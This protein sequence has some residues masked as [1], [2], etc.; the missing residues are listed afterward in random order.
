[1][2]D[3]IDLDR[4]LDELFATPP[5]G[6]TAARNALAKA[7]KAEKRK[8]EADE[9][10]ALRKPGRLV[11]ALNQLGLDED[12][13]LEALLEAADDVRNGGGD[14]FREAVAELRDAVGTAASAAAKRLDPPR[15]TDRA[16]L[17]QALLAI[18]ADDD[19]VSD[20]ADGRLVD[21]PAPDAFG[22]GLPAPATPKAKP[23]PK[24][25]A[26]P[27]AAG[28]ADRPPD[29][30]AIKRAAKR[31]KEAAKEADAADRALAR[32]E[33]AV[34]AEADALAQADTD[35]A[36]AKRAVEDA[37]AALADAKAQLEAA[38][39][40]AAEAVDTQERAAAALAEAQARADDAAA[41]LEEATAEVDALG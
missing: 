2:A 19:A 10:T 17:A 13:A 7:L 36:E 21:V 34:D 26:K 37:E 25:K 8:D 5:E 40:A 3:G 29:Q 20:L 32:A 30:L 22:L 39:S 35:L 1:M 27:K 38:V 15:T 16:D 33:K 23:K 41:E 9:V 12:D 18:V 4:A 24:P 31:Q 11:W 6:F 28:E 14:D